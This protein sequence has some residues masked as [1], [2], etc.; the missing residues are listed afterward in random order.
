M[1]NP[2]P[3][4]HP[5]ADYSSC[6]F[7][8]RRMN[9]SGY[10]KAAEVPRARLPLVGFI[11]LTSGEMLLEV[12][13]VPLL[14]SA[15]QLLL[16]PQERDFAIL[17]YSDACGFTGGFKQAY[18]PE[19]KSIFI[20]PEPFRQA[21]WFDDAAFVGELFN[22]LCNSF[23][24]GDQ[25]FII[26]GLE[27]LF[28]LVKNKKEQAF[29][30]TASTFLDRLF[31]PGAPLSSPADYALEQ[32]ISLNYLNRTVKKAT[33]KPVSTWIDIARLNKAKRLLKDTRE[34]VIDIAAA[35]G[36][37]DQAYFSR[38][39]RNHTGMSPSEFRR[40]MHG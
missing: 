2:V 38:F 27:L 5:D 3:Y 35:V 11:Y 40:V 36:I 23:E 33:G 17:H 39:F 12:E 8:I 34:R 4:W 20:L 10:I 1:V 32:N 37:F 29:P 13:R 31:R 7:F 15:G 6:P 16:I 9:T 24:K 25:A 22:M 14:C 26:K 19:N 28:T 21:F 30:E 18:I